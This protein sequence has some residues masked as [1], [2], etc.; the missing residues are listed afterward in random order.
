MNNG[1]SGGRRVAADIHLPHWRRNYI[2]PSNLGDQS[3]GDDRGE[4]RSATI[5]FGNS[6]ADAEQAEED[7]CATR[8]RAR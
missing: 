1:G 2:L 5:G 4:D 6:G 8:R 3:A 7:A